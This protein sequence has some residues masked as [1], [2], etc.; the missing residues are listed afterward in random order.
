MHGFYWWFYWTLADL[1]KALKGIYNRFT[2]IE[3]ELAVVVMTVSN[4]LEF[5][6]KKTHQLGFALAHTKIGGLKFT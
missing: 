4:I 6:L 2:V 1:Q 3:D 5:A